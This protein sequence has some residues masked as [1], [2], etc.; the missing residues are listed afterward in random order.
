MQ[1]QTGR[2]GQDVGME[3]LFWKLLLSLDCQH[4]IPVHPF[5]ITAWDAKAQRGKE[6]YTT[7]HSVTD[8][9]LEVGFL[10]SKLGHSEAM[11]FST[12]ISF[13]VEQ[14]TFIELLLFT[15]L[16]SQLCEAFKIVRY[17]SC[18]WE[19]F[20]KWLGFSSQ[21]VVQL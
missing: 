11:R 17:N 15:Q 20:R 9:R 14:E 1:V 8:P 6:T 3:L 18:L 5:P 10:N 7:S 2:E 21:L 12:L 16:C 13:R 19:V 4:I